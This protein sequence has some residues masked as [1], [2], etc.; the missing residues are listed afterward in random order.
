MKLLNY[1]VA[2]VALVT[3]ISMTIYPPVTNYAQGKTYD[4]LG[5]KINVVTIIKKLPPLP[6]QAQEKKTDSSQSRFFK[7]VSEWESLQQ[8]LYAEVDRLKNE[9]KALKAQNKALLKHASE[10]VVKIDSANKEYGNQG[11]S[12]SSF[13]SATESVKKKQ[14]SKPSFFR[15]LF[16]SKKNQ[17]K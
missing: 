5:D 11:V 14:K 2:I 8:K 12:S 3:A 6:S 16:H 10:E 7:T 1:T 13:T 4:K 9:N 17:K 15:R